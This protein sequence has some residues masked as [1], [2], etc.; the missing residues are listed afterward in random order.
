MNAARAISDWVHGAKLPVR[1]DIQS[2][3][4][5]EAGT[6]PTT[7]ECEALLQ[8]TNRTYVF[9]GSPLISPLSGFAL[10]RMFEIYE[11]FQ[12]P[13]PATRRLPFYFCFH[14][15]DKGAARPALANAFS[16]MREQLTGFQPVD[17]SL[18][19]IDHERLQ[20]FVVGDLWYGVESWK[21]PHDEYGIIVAQRRDPTTTYCVLAGLSGP[22]TRSC[23]TVLP[24]VDLALPNWDPDPTAKQPIV[25]AVVRSRVELNKRYGD[26]RVVKEKSAELVGRPTMLP[27]PAKVPI[28]RLKSFVK[29]CDAERQATQQG[30]T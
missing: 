2:E 29:L 12:P 6:Y 20:A 14:R 21:F 27:S 3:P 11:P 19:S 17:P 4:P 26:G 18:A 1:V 13:N 16:L 25:Y 15:P 5:R 23:A 7:T 28:E 10:S 30:A 24:E 8:E 22:G 9:I